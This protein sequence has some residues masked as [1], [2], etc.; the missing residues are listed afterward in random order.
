MIVWGGG[1]GGAN[2]FKP[3][4]ANTGGVYDPAADT[5][6][7]TV[8]GGGPEARRS[9][10]AVWTGRSEMILLGGENYEW[11]PGNPD[12]WQGPNPLSDGWRYELQNGAWS[13]VGVSAAREKDTQ[14]SGPGI[15]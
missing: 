10:S 8:G 14:R 9:H 7:P 15:E 13:P 2:Q 6:E 4:V 3:P 12:Y 11:S 1:V 5:W